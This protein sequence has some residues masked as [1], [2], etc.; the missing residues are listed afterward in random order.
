MLVRSGV[1]SAI[2]SLERPIK[3]SDFADYVALADQGRNGIPSILISIMLIVVIWIT[4]TVLA[5][6]LGTIAAIY[7]DPSLSGGEATLAA[8]RGRLGAFTLL[9]SVASFWPAV[10]MGLRLVHRRAFVSVL[11][12][13][14][15]VDRPD[16]WR[17]CAAALVVAMATV[18]PAFLTGGLSESGNINLGQWLIWL[19]PMLALLFFQAS[20]EELFFRGYLS[21]ALAHRFHSPLI[22]AGLPLVSFVLMHWYAGATGAMNAAA[23]FTIAMIAATAAL[24]VYLTGNLGAAFGLHWG[25]NIAA[26]L[27]VSSDDRLGNL[28]LVSTPSLSDP[29]WSIGSS[30]TIAIVGLVTTIAKLALLLHPRSPLALESIR[31]G[32]SRRLLAR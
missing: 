3:N 13:T 28:A 10:W 23:L 12:S 21:Q 26:L 17:G 14:L 2:L 4:A 29:S 18:V 24:L 25:N 31:S 15:R 32:E 22:W 7:F 1:R 8:T 16:M 20:G 9:G 5:L 11:G 6:I 19:L 30:I 27:L